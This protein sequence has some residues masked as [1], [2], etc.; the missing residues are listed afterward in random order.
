[1]PLHADMRSCDPLTLHLLSFCRHRARAKTTQPWNHQVPEVPADCPS[2]V[3]V[4]AQLLP[5]IPQIYTSCT[6]MIPLLAFP[7]VLPYF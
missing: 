3:L 4:S 5:F 2:A 6:A 7:H 1:M